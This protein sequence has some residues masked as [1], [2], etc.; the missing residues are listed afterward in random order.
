MKKQLLLVYNPGAGSQKINHQL[1]NIQWLSENEGFS[2]TCVDLGEFTA[3]N[4]LIIGCSAI[5]VA[6]GDGSVNIVVNRLLSEDIADPP[7]LAILPWGTAND[8]YRQI[9]RKRTA[10]DILAVIKKGNTTRFDIGRVNSHYFVNV[11]AAG[12]FTDVAYLTPGPAKKL[13][14]KPA[15]YLHALGKLL[16][17]RSFKLNIQTE[18]NYLEE[19]VLLFSV[20]NGSQAGGLFTVAPGATLDDGKLHL[21]ALKEGLSIFQY[22]KVLYRAMRGISLDLAGIIYLTAKNLDLEFPAGRLSIIDGEQGPLP[23]L[24]ID[25]LPARLS[26]FIPEQYPDR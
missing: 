21:I 26:F 4:S 14:G 5:V 10:A 15:Y 23:P 17:Y 12:M 1:K 25:L 20:L 8:L 16:T 11:A 19:K 9:Y 13:L 18:C 22:M 3:I 24:K 2:V 7:P 6:G